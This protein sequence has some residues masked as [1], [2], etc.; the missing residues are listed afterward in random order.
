MN[1]NVI[2]A[3]RLGMKINSSQTELPFTDPYCP[4]KHALQTTCHLQASKGQLEPCIAAALCTGTGWYLRRRL[5]RFQCLPVEE[6]P[7]MTGQL[8]ETLYASNDLIWLDKRV[9]L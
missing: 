7:Q 4:A 8:P 6:A 1:A 3:S 2:T 9:T 5:P